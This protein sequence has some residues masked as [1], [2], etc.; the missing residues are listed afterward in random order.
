MLGNSINLTSLL[1]RGLPECVLIVLALHLFNGVKI[2]AKKFVLLNVV[3]AVSISLLR[4]LPTAA[5]VH[6][7]ITLVIM[8]LAFQYIYKLELSMTIRLIISTISVMVLLAISELANMCLLIVLFGMDKTM[9]LVGSED[10]LVYSLS[11]LPSM[12]FFALLIVIAWQG[13]KAWER[14]GTKNGK[15]GKT[16]GK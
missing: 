2:S 12:A 4:L 16:A 5:G 3:C 8:V 15:T 9:E 7:I 14:K 13:L 10:A 1:I 6:S 11:G